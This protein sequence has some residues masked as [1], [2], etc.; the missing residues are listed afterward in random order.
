MLKQ[1]KFIFFILF[2]LFFGNFI[3][4]KIVFDL[5]RTQF[6]E[7]NFFDVGQGE[8]I[9][10]QTPEKNQILIDGGP[11][12]KILEKLAKE[13]PFWDR[14][15]DLMILTHPERDH[16][17]GLIEVL[18][19]YEI[20]NVFWTGV[21]KDI[22]EY[23]EWKKI[24]QKEK[25]KI[26]IAKSGQKIKNSQLMLEILFPSESLE[27]KN[28][29]NTN[30][31]SIIIHL[32]FNKNKF[33]FTGDA[34]K[35]I[36]KKLTEKGI[37]LRSDILKIGHHGSKTSTSEEFIEKVLPKTAIISVGGER[38]MVPNCDNKERNIYGHPNCEVLERLKKFGINVLRTDE[39]GDIKIISDGEKMVIK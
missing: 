6:F 2:S 22:P 26:H 20:E 30:D 39:Y 31:T 27:G 9:F 33:L 35:S 16:L 11:D 34:T 12:S 17:I 3:A 28:L 38:E 32:S 36:E 25:A 23:T 8:A 13:M 19:S 4:W 18:K 7:V 5:A 10:I 15:I 21:K 37:Y 24:I 14:Q 1:E 29:K